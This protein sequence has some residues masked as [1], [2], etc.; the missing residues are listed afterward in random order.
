MPLNYMYLVLNLAKDLLT[1]Y[2]YRCFTPINEKFY[3]SDHVKIP[4]RRGLYRIKA[5]LLPNF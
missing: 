2:V 4:L 3:F 5:H 1:E